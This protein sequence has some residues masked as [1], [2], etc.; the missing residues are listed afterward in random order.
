MS[1]NDGSAQSIRAGV[2][3]LGIMGGA[4]ARHLTKA[5]IPTSGYDLLSANLEAFSVHGGQACS[6]ARAVATEADIVITSL[7]HFAAL[8]SALFGS[9]GVMAA[10]RSDL[11]VVETSTLALDDKER[12][13]DR[14]ASAG[15]GMLDA[16]I[17]GTGPPALSKETTNFR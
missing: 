4:F 7:P 8:D 15:I 3:G 2:I 10:G 1:A 11:L 6:S 9:D 16:P 13:R 5:N 14:L 17:S 12:A